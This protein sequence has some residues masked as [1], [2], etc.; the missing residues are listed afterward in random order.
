MNRI[1]LAIDHGIIEKGS[2]Q[3]VL[4]IHTNNCELASVGVCDCEPR[5]MM[6]L[7]GGGVFIKADGFVDFK[8]LH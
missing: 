8:S 7:P 2:P 5:V 4:V 3:P 1:D 6:R